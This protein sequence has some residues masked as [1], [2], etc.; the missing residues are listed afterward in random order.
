MS[1]QDRLVEV[2]RTALNRSRRL[3][4]RAQVRGQ[5]LRHSPFD[6][7]GG[8]AGAIIAWLRKDSQQV[9][10]ALK[11]ASASLGDPEPDGKGGID[12]ELDVEIK[13]SQMH[14]RNIHE[15]GQ[16]PYTVE[17]DHQP[18]HISGL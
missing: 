3:I 8:I 6:H 9:Y 13:R 14:E 17:K 7:S 16:S 18:Q 11:D 12:G 1:G 5:D 15:V 10:T 4:R 2:T